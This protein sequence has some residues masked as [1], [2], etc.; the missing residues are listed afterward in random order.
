MVVVAQVAL[1]IEATVLAALVLSGAVEVWHL[2]ALSVWSGLAS[3]FDVP[4]RQA[5]IVRFVSGQDLPN[6]IALNSMLMN[7]TRLIGPSLGGLLIAASSETV[8]FVLN[9]VSYI[10]VIAALF[11]VRV[12]RRP[13]RRPTHP[14]SDLAE[15][16]RYVMGNLPIRR[17]LFTL[18]AVSFSISPYTTLMP[19]IAVRI[20]G[21]G[22]ELV[23]FFIG[24]G[25]LGAFVSAVA[26]ARR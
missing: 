4:A 23:G 5:L 3:G 26:L 19:A 13:E 21:E 9:A 8:C 16:W 12:Q 14:L 18:A 11:T 2:I 24:A 20:F 17:M 1:M 22:S 15:G 7:G 25:G 6:A 10:A